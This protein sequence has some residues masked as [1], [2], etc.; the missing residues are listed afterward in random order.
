MDESIIV[1]RTKDFLLGKRKISKC[2]VCQQKMFNNTCRT[3]TDPYITK[4]CLNCPVRLSQNYQGDLCNSCKP[5]KPCSKCRKP[6]PLKFETCR[7]CIPK[8][9]CCKCSEELPFGYK[10]PICLACLPQPKVCTEC[11]GWVHPLAKGKICK[12]CLNT[13][14][15]CNTIDFKGSYQPFGKV[16]Y[17]CSEHLGKC[18]KCPFLLTLPA[19]IRG[20]KYCFQCYQARKKRT[21][22]N[23]NGPIHIDSED[24]NCNSCKFYLESKK[25]NIPSPKEAGRKARHSRI[26]DK[27]TRV[28]SFAQK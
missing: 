22:L 23:C 7:E 16:C 19:T 13:C 25:K 5:R 3:C 21:C 26:P 15:C 9:H 28:V 11:N 1:F 10:E 17:R 20:D 24:L 18:S 6:I 14:V 8:K 12:A 2:G 4:K 27:K